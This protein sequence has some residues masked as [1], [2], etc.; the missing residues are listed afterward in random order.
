MIEGI[1]SGTV[2]RRRIGLPCW[3]MSRMPARLVP[4]GRRNSPALIGSELPK[5]LARMRKSAAEPITFSCSSF[6]ATVLR[7]A[8]RGTVKSASF[9]TTPETHQ[10][11]MNASA[12]TASAMAARRPGRFTSVDLLE[13]Q[14]GVG[15]AEAEAVVEHGLDRPRLG[16]VRHQVDALATR[17]G[18]VEVERRRSHLVAHRQD[19]EDALDRSRAAEQV[20]DRRLG[21][22]H[23]HG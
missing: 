23:G 7:V 10:L 14:A 21:A 9:S 3:M 1:P 13:D 2:T 5:I 15:A 11:A 4:L 18:V 20:P 6:S 17:R 12:S 22:A 16:L 8:P 19:A